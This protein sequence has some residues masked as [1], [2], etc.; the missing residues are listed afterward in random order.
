MDL[1]S[2]NNET[3]RNLEGFRTENMLREPQSQ[4]GNMLFIT[5]FGIGL[6]ILSYVFRVCFTVEAKIDNV[7]NPI[8]VISIASGRQASDG[9]YIE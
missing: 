8:G 5:H 2:H 6:L 4:E 7:A 3:L 1:V 9:S